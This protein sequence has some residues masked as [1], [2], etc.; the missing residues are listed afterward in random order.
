MPEN[1]D[2]DSPSKGQVRVLKDGGVFRAVS[3]H[4]RHIQEDGTVESPGCR[5][6]RKGLEKP[7]SEVALA[8]PKDRSDE[9]T[10]ADEERLSSLA[11]DSFLERVRRA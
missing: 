5:Y 3:A 4:Y 9:D 11:R 10:R 6:C 8:V 1:K 7:F 2:M